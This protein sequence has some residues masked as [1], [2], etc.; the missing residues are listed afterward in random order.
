M[1]VTVAIDCMGVD[2]CATSPCRSA[3]ASR[4]R[5]EVALFWRA[6]PQIRASSGVVMRGNPRL[7]VHPRRVVAM[8]DRRPPRCAAKDSSMR[9]RSISRGRGQACF[10]RAPPGL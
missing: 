1:D 10:R 3:R 6:D 2:H 5:S 4:A 7:R 9:G 8:D